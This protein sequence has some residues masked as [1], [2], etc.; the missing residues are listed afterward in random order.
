VNWL[1]FLLP[2]TRS[3][4]EDWLVDD[5]PKLL[6]IVVVVL[7]VRLFSGPVG[8][9]LLGGA[10][11]SAGR[12]R[13]EPPEVTQRRIS[14]IQGTVSWSITVLASFIGVAVALDVLGVNIAP[15]VAGVG[16]AGIAL[17]LGAQ[18]L[19]KDVIN[20]IF[21]LVEDQYAVGDVVRVAGISGSVV[22]ITP[23]RTVLRDLDGHL[24]SIPNSSITTAT[25]MTRDFS[26]INLNV[27]V[28]YEE[29]LGRVIK[30]INEECEKLAAERPGDILVT[31]GVL[32]VDALGESGI[33]IK[34]TG[35]VRPRT[36]WELMGELRLRLKSRF[37][38]EG[39]EIPYPHRTYVPYRRAVPAAEPGSGD[40]DGQ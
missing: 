3:E 5:A 21:I 28:A 12:L 31:P 20:G 37:N 29:D 8:R 23:R 22:E 26:R 1:P 30:V 11:R 34:V 27:T 14:V 33:E 38:A 13:G 24:H 10:A 9:R 7:A 40:P 32:R 2:S 18:T 4:W 36:Q 25:N 15:L 6:G 39:I 17:G 35:D 19:I 16:V